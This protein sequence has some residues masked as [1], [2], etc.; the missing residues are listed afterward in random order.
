MW[1]SRLKIIAKPANY[2]STNVT[3][4]YHFCP[5][6]ISCHSPYRVGTQL[7][8]EYQIT[9]N[10]NFRST[11]FFILRIGEILWIMNLNELN[12]VQ[13]IALTKGCQFCFYCKIPFFQWRYYFKWSFKGLSSS[14]KSATQRELYKSVQLVFTDYVPSPRHPSG[15]YTDRHTIQMLNWRTIHKPRAEV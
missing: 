1:F 9:W 2:F 13:K 11:Y 15:Q 12:N 10:L 3:D 6:Y 8:A 4:Y 7:S 14:F 5:Y